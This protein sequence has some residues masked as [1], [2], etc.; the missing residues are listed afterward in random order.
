MNVF[1]SKLIS[2][3]SIWVIIAKIQA[4]IYIKINAN[5]LTIIAMNDLFFIQIYYIKCIYMTLYIKSLNPIPIVCNSDAII[6]PFTM[7]I[8]IVNT[9]ITSFT[10]L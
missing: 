2:L 4:A 7:M 8:K 9:S 5:K 1:S 6:Y 3:S 10:M